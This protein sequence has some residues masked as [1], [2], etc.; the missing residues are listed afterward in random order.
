MTEGR[1]GCDELDKLGLMVKVNESISRFIF[2]NCVS[3]SPNVATQV[4]AIN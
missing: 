2:V 3:T 1:K 4:F